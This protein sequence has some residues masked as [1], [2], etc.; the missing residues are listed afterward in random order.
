[1]FASIN[2]HPCHETK[3]RWSVS[4]KRETRLRSGVA[5]RGYIKE[6]S[7]IASLVRASREENDLI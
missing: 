3:A 4:E 7:L 2:F 1:M 5:R 6:E